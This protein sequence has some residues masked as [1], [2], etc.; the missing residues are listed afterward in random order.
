MQA[1]PYGKLPFLASH[2][3][4]LPA[5]N[6]VLVVFAVAAVFASSSG[7]IDGQSLPLAP[8]HQSEVSGDGDRV[9][10]ADEYGKL[11]LS[12]EPAPDAGS[13]EFIARTAGGTILL[14]K[15]MVLTVRRP[16]PPAH[17]FGHPSLYPPSILRVALQGSNPGAQ[18]RGAG[19][20]P[21]KSNFFFGDDKKSW[22]TDVP[23]YSRVEYSDVYPGIDLVYYG[24]RSGHL[25]HDFIVKPNANPAAIQLRLAGT[26]SVK[27]LETGGLQLELAHRAGDRGETATLRSPLLYQEVDGKRIAVP[28]EYTIQA[29]GLIGFQIGRYDRSRDLVID[30]V[31]DYSTFLGG[32]VLTSAYG[33][34]VDGGGNAYVVGHS[35]V[36]GSFPTTKGS[37]DP[38]CDDCS[39]AFVAKLNPTGTALLYSTY[40]AS[41]GFTQANGVAVD[42]A[43][44]AYVAGMTSGGYPVTKGAFQT[45]F[46]GGFSNGFVTK[47]NPAGSALD[48]STYLGGNGPSTCYTESVGAQGDQAKAIAIDSAGDAY[49]TGCTSSANFPVSKTALEKSCLGCEAG[50]AS[51]YAAKLNP[52]GT[53]LLYSTFLGGDGLDFGFGIGVDSASEAFVVG[54]TTS[55][56][57]K[58]TSSAYQ[59]HLGGSGAQN[60]FVVKLNPAATVADYYTYLGG[61]TVDGA[62]AIAVAP[63]GH[64][65][66]AGYAS[67]TDFPVTKGA[68]QTTCHDCANDETGFVAEFNYGGTALVFSTFLGGSGFDAAT[69]IGVDANQDVFVSGATQSTNFPTT[70]NALKKTCSQCSTGTGRSSATLTE[71][72]P[73]GSA[74][75]YSTYVGGSSSD[76]GTAVAVDSA[77]N[78]YTVGQV[79]SVDFPISAA[80][81]QQSCAACSGGETAAFTTKFYF[82]GSTA[83]L[84]FSPASLNFGNQALK[85]ASKP[86]SVTLKNNGAGPLQVGG[87]ALTGADHGDFSGSQ[88]CGAAIPAGISCTAKITFTPAALGSRAAELEVADSEAGSPQ[89]VKLS[90]TGVNPAPIATFSPTSLNLGNIM[91][92]TVGTGTI[93]LTNTGTAGLT[94]SADSFSGTDAADF[95]GNTTC[96]G[97]LS[98]GGSCTFTIGIEPTKEQTYTADL[99][100]TTNASSKAVQIPLSAKGI[101]DA[102]AVKLSAT[103]IDFPSELVGTA[104]AGSDI[105]VTNTGALN[106]IFKSISIA[107]ADPK[108]FSGED[109]CGSGLTPGSSCI[110]QLVFKPT[111][112][113]ARSA[114]LEFSDNASGSPQSVTLNGSG[115]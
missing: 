111:A 34:A 13:P 102:P 30:P 7:L 1:R 52:T 53:E 86:L 16:E 92:G 24:D 103:V 38:N 80:A 106:L 89:I 63:N 43:G 32:G 65:F 70:S 22:R 37:Y 51:A 50:Y 66:V 44:A 35:G 21:G 90:G 105:T 75:L 82:G 87:Y 36:G 91:V 55:P 3:R 25:E 6:W 71:L 68:Y 17:D 27:R 93:T 9:A 101:A 29:S 99:N 85:Q 47:L 79:T 58:T 76:N 59:K 20:L 62:Y 46:G 45:T 10:I 5:T 114:L 109:N 19:E 97:T 15:Q 49:V 56:N 108:D 72:N 69:G 11:P 95:G 84:G 83:S 23:N 73:A 31:L 78:A 57:L 74:L 107:G 2:V 40:L 4:R 100:V 61:D 41:G 81:V 42:S 28:G 112:T 39:A 12:F 98:P 33:I 60:A 67:S 88:N 18:P 8:S 26:E 110:V 96:G 77:G 64:A 104:S 48:Y 94:V 54:S 14:G 115:K 113:G